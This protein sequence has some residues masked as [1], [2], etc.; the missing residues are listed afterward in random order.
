MELWD[1]FDKDRMP[2]GKT[3]A[4]GDVRPRGEY[5]QTV[6]ICIFDPSG[7]LLI[8]RRAETKDTF[9]SLWDITAA[10][11]VLSG[12]HSCE[13]AHRE[14][15]EEIGVDLDFSGVRPYFTLN[16]EGGFGDFYIFVLEEIDL[17]ALRLQESEV[18]AVRY[19]TLEEALALIDEGR[20]IPYHHSFI[21]LLFDMR[22]T[23][24]MHNLRGEIK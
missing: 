23:G 6:H 19:A 4:R 24:S 21:K 7:R 16:H 14:L 20:F 18:Q 8:Q 17:S 3:M 10:G 13:G 2:L 11:S 22:G 15:L 9:A 1:L 5:H 12:E